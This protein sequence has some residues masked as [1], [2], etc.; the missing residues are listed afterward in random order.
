[1][2]GLKNVMIIFSGY[3]LIAI[4]QD[5]MSTP[6][7]SLKNRLNYLELIRLSVKESLK[8]LRY[9]AILLASKLILEVELLQSKVM[10]EQ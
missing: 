1:M 5:S 9:I 2:N 7:H 6:F 4:S 10:R 3:S 8:V